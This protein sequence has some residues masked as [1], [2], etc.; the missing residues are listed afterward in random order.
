MLR[1]LVLAISAVTI[2]APA[3]ADTVTSRIV[4]VDADKRVITLADK[5]IMVVG[6]DVDL[7][8]VPTGQPVTLST[9]IDENGFTPISSI[10]PQ[11]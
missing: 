11:G 6:K 4:K 3:I 1:T 10:K 5:T 9:S 7:S 8:T 2:A